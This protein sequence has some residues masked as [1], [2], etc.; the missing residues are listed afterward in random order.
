MQLTT[1]G[2]LPLIHTVASVEIIEELL[3][4]DVD[5]GMIGCPAWCITDRVAAC[6]EAKGDAIQP[7][8]GG[9]AVQSS[10]HRSWRSPAPWSERRARAKTP[11]LSHAWKRIPWQ[12]GLQ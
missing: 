9:L 12:R 3:R 11:G 8:G 10:S 2:V 7:P 4:Q 5:P 1:K 6:V